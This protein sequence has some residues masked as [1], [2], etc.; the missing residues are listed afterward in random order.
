RSAAMTANSSPDPM[1]S[2]LGALARQGAGHAVHFV[3]GAMSGATHALGD[4]VRALAKAS[5]G[6]I[7]TTFFYE[8][9][10]AQDVQGDA[11]DEAG[12]VTPD[13]L[14]RH[15]PLATRT[16]SC[17]GPAPSCAPS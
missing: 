16:I 8:K 6:R 7:R 1:V 11:Y 4:E 10:R 13:W 17:A 3:H 2:M 15:T 14:A 5:G 12:L 9:P